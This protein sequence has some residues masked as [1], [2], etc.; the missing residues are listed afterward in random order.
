MLTIAVG[1]SRKE[2]HW[3][4]TELMWSQLVERLS[5]TTRTS[6][7]MDEYA[8]GSKEFQDSKKDVGGF[9]GGAVS[10]SGAGDAAVGAFQGCAAVDPDTIGCTRLRSDGSHGRV[11]DLVGLEQP[12]AVAP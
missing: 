11:D 2:T 10:L 5:K 9:V 8:K 1:A 7:T 4:T 12:V 6:E 3:R